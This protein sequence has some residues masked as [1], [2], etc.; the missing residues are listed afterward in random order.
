[1]KNGISICTGLLWVS[2]WLGLMLLYTLLDI[3]VWRR[4]APAPAGCFN[5]ISITLCTAAF[6]FLLSK[7]NHFKINLLQNISPNGILLAAGCTALFYFVLDR[8]LDPAL[9]K[10]FPMSEEKYKEALASLSAAPV[11]ALLQVCILA[12]LLEEILMRG[13]L[14]GGLSARY[15]KPAALLISALVF[16]L[17]HFN[18]V[19]TLSAFICG[20]ILGLLY[21]HTGSLFCCIAAHAGYNFVS[22]ITAVLP[23]CKKP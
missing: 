18:M 16:A 2:A 15:G 8:G 11:A 3:A 6:L 1:M 21:L 23:L 5:I 9:A 20:L 13:F 22:F 4:L 7:R 10:A 12:P 14:L 19:Q 17:L